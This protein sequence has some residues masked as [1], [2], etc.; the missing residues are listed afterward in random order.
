MDKYPLSY[1]GTFVVV[2]NVEGIPADDRST[3]A[4][5]VVAAAT[6]TSPSAGINA[7]DA[8]AHSRTVS[9]SAV[10]AAVDCCVSPHPAQPPIGIR[11]TDVIESVAKIATASPR[12][13]Y[14]E[15]A[16][17]LLKQEKKNNNERAGEDSNERESI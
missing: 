15:M 14:L 6:S 4:D 3:I 2:E 11:R 1:R 13:M 9:V 8:P 16:V 5:S 10:T 17:A 12:K 7:A